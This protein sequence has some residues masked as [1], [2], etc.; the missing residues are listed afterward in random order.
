MSEDEN[1]PANIDQDTEGAIDRLDDVYE[2]IDR[3]DMEQQKYINMKIFTSMT[4]KE[5]GQ[6]LGIS[7]NTMRKWDKDPDCQMFEKECQKQY[8]KDTI[9]T[10]AKQN[11]FLQN[12]VFADLMGR[13]R[14]P[15]PDND[16][17]EDAS[18]YEKKRY[19]ERF[20]QNMH[21]KDAMK[22]WEKIDKHVRLDSPDAKQDLIED[23]VFVAEV[24]RR[25]STIERK[26]K[27]VERLREE[28][29]A[30]Q[31]EDKD[32]NSIEAELIEPGSEG[33][34]DESE[35]ETVTETFEMEEYTIRTK[36]E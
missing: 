34:S 1:L 22:V 36:G 7:Y 33:G 26:R 30:A 5:I 31:V 3:V 35:Y 9:D 11:V 24:K 8:Q 17:P 4:K 29:Q 15:D 23:N 19:A 2:S 27:A 13:F 10:L 25:R 12:H 28:Y 6:V 14:T 18:S 32:G 20:F 21:A 16:L